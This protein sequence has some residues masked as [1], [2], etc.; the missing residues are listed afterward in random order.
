M[1]ESVSS[2]HQGK[3]NKVNKAGVL[4]APQL[5][6]WAVVSDFEVRDDN[7]FASDLVIETIERRVSRGDRLED[8]FVA[9]DKAIRLA[10]DRDQSDHD[11]MVRA[12][13]VQTH[14]SHYVPVKVSQS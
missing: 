6:L 2:C 12:V 11:S 7:L 3:A 1:L 8:S 14:T 5:G 9:A 10:V 13:A 4:E